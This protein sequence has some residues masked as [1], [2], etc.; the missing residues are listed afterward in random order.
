MSKENVGSKVMPSPSLSREPKAC[1]YFREL[2]K[3][4]LIARHRHLTQAGDFSG[5]T[6][7]DQHG[8]RKRT[9]NHWVK[10]RSMSVL[11][12]RRLDCTPASAA[13]KVCH[14]WGSS[15]KETVPKLCQNPLVWRRWGCN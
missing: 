2:V 3:P 15:P 12:I 13:P 5:K 14:K 4:L 6:V 7:K 9:P 10:T 8:D 11:S 1:S